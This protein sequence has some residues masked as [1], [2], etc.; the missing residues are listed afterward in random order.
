MIGTGNE[1]FT[2][3]FMSCDRAYVLPAILENGYLEAV[4]DVCRK[5]AITAAVCLSDLDISVLAQGRE[6]LARLGVACFFPDYRI[7]MR[8]LDKIQTA[9]YLEECGFQTPATFRDLDKAIDSIGFPIVVKP[10]HG[11]ASIGFGLFHDEHSAKRHW[12]SLDAPMAQAYLSGRL[13]NVEACSSPDGQLLAISAWERHSSVAGETLLSET[14]DHPSALELVE[15][16]LKRC[17][18]PGPV[19]VDI[20]D[21]GG[22]LYILEVNTRFGGGYPTS[23][24]AGADFPGVMV[25]HLQGQPSG[26]SRRYRRGIYMMK[27]LDPV[28]YDLAKVHKALPS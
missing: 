6:M 28:A 2:P 21:V 18:I 22:E 24:L 9:E 1:K 5:E 17:P 7:A 27:E 11:S 16:L 23:H 14:I 8:F 10:S 19:D 15:A 26:V 25:A 13:I 12:D 4:H 20:V 3:G